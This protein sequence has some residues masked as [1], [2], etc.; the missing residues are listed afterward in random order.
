MMTDVPG[1]EAA[2][3]ADWR[4]ALERG[5]F[6]LAHQSYRLQ[7]GQDDGL[8]EALDALGQVEA[9][10]RDK[11]W[12]RA[13][14][15]LAA[16]EARPPVLD[17][18]VLEADL[19]ALRSAGEA[20][21]RRQPDDALRALEELRSDYFMAE[22]ETLAGTA[23]IYD[24]RLDEARDRFERA[25]AVDPNHYRALTNFGNVALEQGRV[26]E[27]IASYQR[28]LKLNDGFA[29]AHHNLGVAYRRKGNVAQSVRELR[30]AQRAMQRQDAD[31]ARERLRSGAR[32]ATKWLRWALYALVAVTLWW[33]LRSRGLL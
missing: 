19:E 14:K 11:A 2:A 31:E 9:L 25:L 4:A 21:D 18:S 28:A 33:I 26:D 20:L 27:A 6:G 30:K 32:N 1:T 16:V 12:A 29:N 17:W 3:A 5:R 8:R 10:V 23:L 15:R 7:G 22:R 13:H 24:S